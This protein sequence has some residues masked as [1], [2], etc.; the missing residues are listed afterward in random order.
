MVCRVRHDDSESEVCE[1]RVTVLV[2]QDIGLWTSQPGD[3]RVVLTLK[4]L[5]P[6]DPHVLPPRRAYM[7]IPGQHP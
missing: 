4:D 6:L 1:A 5:P 7:P 2:D 3:S